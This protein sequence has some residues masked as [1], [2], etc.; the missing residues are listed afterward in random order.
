VKLRRPNRHRGDGGDD[1][2]VPLIN[3]IFLML[4]FFMI[5]ARFAPLEPL[6][7]APP[8]SSQAPPGSMADRTILLAADGRVAVGE[9]IVEP[10]ALA[11]TLRDWS[12][13]DGWRTGAGPV[14][15]AAA[16]VTLKADADVHAEQLRMLLARLREAGIER[17]R[18]V[19]AAAN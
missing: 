4:I 9:R 5:A 3:I 8:R 2:L 10:A 11:A 17:V 16:P 13:A 19:T 1:H 15:L 18:L 7:V 14:G 12:A 6:D